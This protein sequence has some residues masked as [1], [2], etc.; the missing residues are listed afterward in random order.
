MESVAIRILYAVIDM[1]E[2]SLMEALVLIRAQW[3]AVSKMCKCVCTV[4]PVHPT[5]VANVD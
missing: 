5:Y 4:P 3:S 2:F 1:E